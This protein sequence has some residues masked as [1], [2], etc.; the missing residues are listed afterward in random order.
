MLFTR[1]LARGYTQ[2][3]LKPIFNTYLQR[4]LT[5][6]ATATPATTANTT[7]VNDR[8]F[9]HLP[10]HPKDPKSTEIQALFRKHLL[11]ENPKNPYA[12]TPLYRLSNNKRISLGIRCMTVAY[13]RPRNLGNMIAPQCIDCIPSLSAMAFCNKVRRKRAGL[14]QHH[15]HQQQQQQ[16]NL[17]VAAP[18]ASSHGTGSA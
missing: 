3:H 15:H 6:Q 14:Q 2:S 12:S 8:I 5:V 18:M 4:Y 16:Q 17:Q 10:F 1:L 7:T 13:H 11:K 9:L